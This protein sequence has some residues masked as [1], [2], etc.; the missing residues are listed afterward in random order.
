MTSPDTPTF[1]S[2]L[3]VPSSLPPPS[4]GCGSCLDPKSFLVSVLLPL[5]PRY[6]H[7]SMDERKHRSDTVDRR[8]STISTK[9]KI[10]C[11]ADICHSLAVATLPFCLRLHPTC[12]PLSGNRQNPA[13]AKIIAFGEPVSPCPLLH[14]S[15]VLA[16]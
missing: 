2:P 8:M 7:I 11:V 12:H 15:P 13:S 6:S 3:P 9:W 14:I 10:M 5:L 16:A 4:S 1:M